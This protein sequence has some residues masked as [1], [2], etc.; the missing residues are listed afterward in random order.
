MP[1][2][3]EEFLRYDSPV[4]FTHRVAQEDLAL[5]GKT[6]RA[7]QIVCLMLAAANR[8]PAQFPTPTGWTSTRRTT[9]TWPSARGRT[10][11]WGR[12][13]PAWR[14]RSPSGRCC[15]GSRT[16]SLA[17][18]RLEYRETFNLHG[19]KELPVRFGAGG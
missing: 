5:G 11:A 17:S 1:G 2:A 10:S 13:W 14:P 7:G 15:G 3:V 9:S 18:R 4:Q 19:L 6:I 16:V 12:R 8:D